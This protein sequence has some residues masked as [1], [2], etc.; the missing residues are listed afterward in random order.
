M[1]G[2]K[3]D[4]GVP[5]VIETNGKTLKEALETVEVAMVAQTLEDCKWNKMQA[6]KKLGIS[7]QALYNKI[8][9]FVEMKP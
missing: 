9:R 7:R 5:M 1:A 6:A 8:K 2:T 4:S 3:R